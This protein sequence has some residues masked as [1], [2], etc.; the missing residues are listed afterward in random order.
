[1]G[2]RVA[3]SSL[4]LRWAARRTGKTLDALREQFPRI[5]AWESG[6]SAPALQQL[7]D[8]ASDSTTLSTSIRP[9]LFR[10]F[11]DQAK[12]ESD[13]SVLSLR[14]RNRAS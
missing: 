13:A 11:G 2:T 7:E 1:M 3:V 8:F 5:E 12:N 4:V 10:G 9:H 14:A 6:E